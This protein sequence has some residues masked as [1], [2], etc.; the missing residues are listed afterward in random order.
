MKGTDPCVLMTRKTTMSYLPSSRL[1]ERDPEPTPE[2]AAPKAASVVAAPTPAAP[3]AVMSYPAAPKPAP[4]APRPATMLPKEWLVASAP[5]LRVEASV[6]PPVFASPAAESPVVVVAPRTKE[7]VTRP[8][9]AGPTSSADEPPARK[10]NIFHKA[11]KVVLRHLDRAK[12]KAHEQ[13]EPD[14]LWFAVMVTGSLCMGLMIWGAYSALPRF[15][16]VRAPLRADAS[17]SKLKVSNNVPVRWVHESGSIQPQGHVPPLVPPLV[18]PVAPTVVPHE[19]P[20]HGIPVSTPPPH[21]EPWQPSGLPEVRERVAPIHVE[22]PLTSLP[23]RKDPAIFV[24]NPGETPMIRTWKKLAESSML[25]TAFT[26]ASANNLLAGLPAQVP[27]DYSKQI[28][29]LT[30]SVKALSDQVGNLKLDDKLN[31]VKT[32][33]NE[34]ISKI[35]LDAPKTDNSNEFLLLA[36]RLEQMEKLINQMIKNPAAPNPGQALA[37]NVNLDEIKSKLGSIEQA[38][39]RL[40]PSEKRIALS[41]PD[42]P[43]TKTGT[44]HVIFVNLYNQDLWLWV[45]QKQHRAPANSTLTLDNITAGPATIEVRSPEGIFHKSNPTL[46]ANETFTLTAR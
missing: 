35:K 25:L 3:A 33:L 22:P 11:H 45:N 9:S 21:H 10:R 27:I 19:S 30:K 42:L 18:P 40:Q 15:G 36:N 12:T 24:A 2:A 41:A 38:I 4:P 5:V 1:Y 39:L 16:N 34:K 7:T 44:S 28:E 26:A 37:G 43:V 14:L 32:E 23:E 17:T 31:A 46:V 6:P 8:A 29:E 13:S 20:L